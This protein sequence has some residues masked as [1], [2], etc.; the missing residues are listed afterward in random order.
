MSVGMMPL[1]APTTCGCRYP[2]A[3]L[4]R[5]NPSTAAFLGTL[6]P[7]LPRRSRSYQ[8]V[9]R[10]GPAPHSKRDYPS[11]ANDKMFFRLHPGVEIE[12]HELS[13]VYG[14][15]KNLQE[16]YELKEKIGEGNYGVVYKAVDRQTGVEY[17]CKTVSKIPRGKSCSNSHH[18]LK[19]RSEVDSMFH[20]GSSLD[21]VFLREV[22][23]D[24]HSIHLVMELCSGGTLMESVNREHI[25][26]QY[27]ATIMRSVLRFLAQCHSSGLVY[28]D[29]K[30][31]NFLFTSTQIDRT[32]KATDFGLMIKL[33]R[34]KQPLTTPAGTPIYL[35][36]EV[37]KQSYRQEADVYSAGVLAFQLLTGRYPYW[38]SMKFKAPTMHQLFDIITDDPIDFS[39]LS[40]EGVSEAGQDFLKKLLVKRPEDRISAAA[41][42]A[43]PW[44]QEADSS[45]EVP[46]N[47]T[48][49]Q[50]LQRFA[51]S[52]K[53]KKVVL[54]M[55]TDDIIDGSSNI[56]ST[57]EASQI[58]APARD[59]FTRL[60]LD[61]SGDVSVD[62]L[63]VELSREG[64]F[65]TDHEVEQLMT[66]ID[67][68]GDGKIVFDEL[69]SSLLDW[70]EFETSAQWLKL[71][72]RA[73]QRMDLNGDGMI[74]LEEVISLLPT[75]L[76][77][78]ERDEAAR[79]MIREFD[80]DGD[81]NISWEEFLNLLME[82]S[83]PASLVFFDKRLSQSSSGSGMV[84]VTPAGLLAS[85]SEDFE[86]GNANEDLLYYI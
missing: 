46:L 56:F 77:N 28:R 33:P 70:N 71:A 66:R 42:L 45:S 64:Y 51:V 38:P 63:K 8:V 40:A 67:A 86:P 24:D 31:E 60:D 18:L 3:A 59:I 22:C 7:P 43:H 83:T 57:M 37:V 32:L 65:L 75:S 84:V 85:S 27:F 9:V 35:A 29:V 13:A 80:T 39:G 20:L 17:A 62:E 55:I 1:A 15:A 2:A 14:Y 79:S 30:P 6:R 54:T 11:S 69:V 68:N 25:S 47:G 48:V 21:G 81:G 36:P 78:A 34:G 16:R 53:L 10:S 49:V 72:R 76:S 74:N 5:L 52:G 41:A 4:D 12:P 44:L 23:E 19:I 73:F 26:E 61:A 58:L 50:R 82:G